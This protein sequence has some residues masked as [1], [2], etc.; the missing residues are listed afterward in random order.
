MYIRQN[1]NWLSLRKLKQATRS[2]GRYQVVYKSVF[3]ENDFCAPPSFRRFDTRNW[4]FKGT[5]IRKWEQDNNG[6]THVY[7]NKAH[8]RVKQTHEP[9][10]DINGNYLI[11]NNSFTQRDGRYTTVHLQLALEEPMAQPIHVLGNFN[12]WARSPQTRMR[13]DST[14]NRYSTEINLKQGYYEYLY[15]TQNDSFEAIEGCW[16]HSENE[17]EVMIYYVDRDNWTEPMVGYLRFQ[18]S[19]K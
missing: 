14:T 3:G 7:L 18:N 1:R 4:Y 6:L 11:G 15:W 5:G 12:H 13:Y 10:P 9:L 16:A 17:Y 8:S 19:L 2:Q